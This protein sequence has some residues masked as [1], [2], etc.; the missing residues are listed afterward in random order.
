MTKGALR[1]LLAWAYPAALGGVLGSAVATAPSTPLTPWWL[2]AAA[3]GLALVAPLARQGGSLAVRWMLV[4]GAC[5]VLCA[6]SGL[7]WA[8]RPDAWA[9]SLAREALI[10][11][12]GLSDGTLL[13]VP[14]RGRLLLRGSVVPAGEVTLEGVLTPLSG[15]RNP[16]GF[17]EAAFWRRRGVSAGLRVE[18]VLEHAAP[19][20]LLA[21]RE[22]LRLGVTAGL[23]SRPGA[24]MQAMT[25]GLRHELGD[26]RAVFAGAGMAHLLALS[27]L[28]VG[29][30]AGVVMLL[31]RPLGPRRSGGLVLAV[32]IVYVLLVGPGPSVVRAACMVAAVVFAR[33][34]D[35]RR[36]PL[37]ASLAL[38]A[39]ACALF[40][41]AWVGD[42]GFQ[43]S[44]LSV[45][46]IAALAAP[47]L[48]AAHPAR[49]R[50]QA[51]RGRTG[52]GAGE[53]VGA[54][55]RYLWA[56]LATSSS[57]QAATLSLVAGSFGAVPLLAP[58]ANVVA[59]P[60]A[61][62][63]VPLG[64]LAGLAG[65]VHPA[66]AGGV[67]VITAP[68]AEALL[69]FAGFA[70]RGPSLHWGEVGMEGHLLLGCALV[71][72][73]LAVRSSMRWRSAL[74]VVACASAV[75]WSVPDSRGVPELVVLDVG[76]GDAVII[77]LG[78]GAAVLVDGGGVTFA[79][80]D[81]GERVVVPALRA[82]GV[83]RLPLVVATHADLDHVGGLPAVLRAFPVAEL[84]IGHPA[85]ERTAWQALAAV[86]RQRGVAVREVRRGEAVRLGEVGVDVLHPTHEASGE[87]NADS[88]AL[89]VRYR[90]EAWALLLGDV[91]DLVEVDLPV[92]P[93]PV[94]MAP[95]HGSASST[96]AALLRSAGPELVLISVGRNRYGHPS[97]EVLA[98]LEA[99]GVPVLATLNHGAL[100]LPPGRACAYPEL[101]RPGQVTAGTC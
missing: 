39:F 36:P 96:S 26:L 82:L 70:S 7:H 30:L 31:A 67:N 63:L 19:A 18:Q 92:P 81:M 25:L 59:V 80:F 48:R 99:A 97:A 58:L 83:W 40:A 53:F 78:G 21:A 86:A 4:C 54:G 88:V 65:V 55:G 79:G 47:A 76:Q 64:A 22:S 15:R 27:G 60:L 44:F 42:L 57:A 95:H 98:R 23:D 29:V 17:D 3:L 6:G 84:W 16:G 11:V 10:E 100:R 75:A 91:P 12:R 35:V 85:P 61:S 89:L 72:L 8:R 5:F 68:L 90:G 74:L 24:L 34:F 13:R 93:T 45:L 94:L 49:R 52:S 14:G 56:A 73:A 41:P 32:V 71:A 33:L 9:G 1:P 43:L 37:P 87:G 2:A 20:G 51:F 46:G 101:S 69:A 66:L 50:A 62:A 38:A 77:R 28:H